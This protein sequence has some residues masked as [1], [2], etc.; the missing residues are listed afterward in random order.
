MGKGKGKKRGSAA[1]ARGTD[2]G[3]TT[4]I[5]V[6][7]M[8]AEA[9]VDIAEASM[10]GLDGW[11]RFVRAESAPGLVCVH[12]P[13]VERHRAAAGNVPA[14]R[15]G[16]LALLSADAR[17]RQH[18]GVGLT[19]EEAKELTNRL[20]EGIAEAERVAAAALA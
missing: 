19:V 20:I 15:G 16:M 9:F 12:V 17:L 1:S 10:R 13:T 6:G 18:C 2:V 14:S 8:T 7:A 4:T 3:Q 5:V 11:Q